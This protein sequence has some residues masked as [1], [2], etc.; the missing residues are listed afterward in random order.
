VKLK[1]VPLSIVVGILAAIWTWVSIKLSLPT[2]AGFMGWAFFFVAGSDTAAIWKASLPGTA[3]VIL[4]HLS[5]Y[6]LKLGGEMGYIGLSVLV[7]LAA[8]ILVLA[9][10][11]APMALAP[12]GFV[13]FAAFFAYVFGAPRDPNVF[14][15]VNILY[16]LAGLLIGVALGWASVKIT[17]LVEK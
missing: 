9:M 7:G 13:W 4:G 2:W 15:F 8:L 14:A 3:G 5:L 10:N 16:P 1:Y 12:A 17:A 11:W 6:G